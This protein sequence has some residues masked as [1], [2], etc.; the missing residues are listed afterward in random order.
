MLPIYL[1]IALIIIIV[2][3]VIIRWIIT[4]TVRLTTIPTARHPPQFVPELSPISIWVINVHRKH[5]PRAKYAKRVGNMGE[6]A[7]AHLRNL[8]STLRFSQLNGNKKERMRPSNHCLVM[9]AVFVQ[10]SH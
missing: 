7:R 1:L 10:S 9:A 5:E 3:S 4:H 2:I 8:L 6:L